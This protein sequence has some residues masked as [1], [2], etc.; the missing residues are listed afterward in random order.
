MAFHTR[1]DI[2]TLYINA[3]LFPQNLNPEVLMSTD[4][5]RFMEAMADKP[6]TAESLVEVWFGLIEKDL[7]RMRQ[8]DRLSKLWKGENRE[9]YLALE[10]DGLK[11]VAEPLVEQPIVEE[12]I[13]LYIEKLDEFFP[14]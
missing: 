6:L 4:T 14:E 8:S 11:L 12:A 2:E 10:S 9:D 5:W 1:E 3:G 13:R 7:V